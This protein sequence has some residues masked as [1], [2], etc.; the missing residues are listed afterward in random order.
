MA[1][2]DFGSTRLRTAH[3]LACALFALLEG[4]AAFGQSSTAAAAPMPTATSAATAAGSVRIEPAVG[5]SFALEANRQ[6]ITAIFQPR[7]LETIAQ[8]P[9]S[10]RRGASTYSALI[11]P[12]GGQSLL[13]AGDANE[14]YAYLA[15]NNINYPQY[16]DFKRF[17]GAGGR[18]KVVLVLVNFN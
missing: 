2:S 18:L 9:R 3:K 12:T 5:G 8:F 1:P 16:S 7:S 11:A 14:V 15:I 6:A 13:Y 17:I 10:G 4:A